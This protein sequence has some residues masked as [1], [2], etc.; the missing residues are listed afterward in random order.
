MCYDTLPLAV[1]LKDE[2]GLPTLLTT[3]ADKSITLGL[4]ILTLPS[5]SAFHTLPLVVDKKGDGDCWA[6]QPFLQ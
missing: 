3:Q 4:I 2:V 1:D 6:A 5:G